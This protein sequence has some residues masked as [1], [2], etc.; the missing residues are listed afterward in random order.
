MQYLAN[1]QPQVLDQST[2]SGGQFFNP[3]WQM[4]TGTMT[5]CF[6]CPFS[7][8][9]DDFLKVDFQLNRASEVSV[10]IRLFFAV[11]RLCFGMARISTA[12]LSRRRQV[13]SSC[14]A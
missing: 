7:P 3:T 9:N 13:N 12:G 8:L 14:G 6:A 10:S 5:S 2:T 1:G 11:T 4:A